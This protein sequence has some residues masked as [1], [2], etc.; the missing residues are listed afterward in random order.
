MSNKDLKTKNTNQES[1]GIRRWFL[2]ATPLAF[3]G[4]IILLSRVS[5]SI[6]ISNQQFLSDLDLVNRPALA[7]MLATSYLI[8][9][10][11]TQSI[12]GPI[13]DKIG[14][15]NTGIVASIIW[16]LTMAVSGL[17]TTAGQIIIGRIILGVGQGVMFPLF[18]VY[19]GNWF[20]PKERG[21]A[22]AF[23][24][25]GTTVGPVLSGIIVV[26]MIASGG[27]RYA[28]YL[29]GLIS[30]LP[31]IPIIFLMKEYPSQSKWMSKM[32]LLILKQE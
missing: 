13:I 3:I 32:K 15:R 21:R 2:M 8:T 6:L 27:W 29:H 23:W 16:A 10:A 25:N 5:V 20:P 9:Y 30:L 18:N 14:P 19:V 4:A 7:G 26:A 11:L 28:F 12:W 31:L 17:S 22:S 24:L 1:V